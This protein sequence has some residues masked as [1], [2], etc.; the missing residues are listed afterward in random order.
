[1]G[2]FSGLSRAFKS[3]VS[4]PTRLLGGVAKAAGGILDP[5]G[6]LIG[7]AA[8]SIFGGGSRFVAPQFKY[9]KVDMQKHGKRSKWYTDQ[10][11]Q[12]TLDTTGGNQFD[13]VTGKRLELASGMPT[14]QSA[15]AG[16][17]LPGRLNVGAQRT[18][19]N[20]NV[21]GAA[22]ELMDPT[23][24]GG[25]RDITSTRFGGGSTRTSLS[26]VLAAQ[27]GDVSQTGL[28]YTGTDLA[29]AQAGDA[30]IG[31]RYNRGDIDAY[32]R[33]GTTGQ[34]DLD[35]LA[36]SGIL[37]DWQTGNINARTRQLM[38]QRTDAANRSIQ[39]AQ[40]NRTKQ[41]TSSRSSGWDSNIAKA[42]ALGLIR[43]F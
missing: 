39:Q 34:A 42:H 7:G 33:G 37:S 17:Y 1:M 26:D 5:I 11:Q 22:N 8:Q 10:L 40:F 28:H 36:Q 24:S 38:N 31:G 14:A 6:N 12:A 35:R 3:I 21:A 41:N 23:Q 16:N 27:A 2:F 25:G 15:G 9:N 18:S 29:R 30:S 43:P 32:I 20:P 13:P 4:A 19:Y